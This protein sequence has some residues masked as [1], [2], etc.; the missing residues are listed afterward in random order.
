MSST[1]ESL[2]TIAKQLS[3][4]E[5]SQKAAIRNIEAHA[6]IVKHMEEQMESIIRESVRIIDAVT[7]I[8]ALAVKLQT[9]TDKAKKRVDGI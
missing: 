2:R 1:S 7:D 9:H 8:A 6:E 5:M 4:G 3:L